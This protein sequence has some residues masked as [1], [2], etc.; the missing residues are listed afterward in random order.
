ML[1]LGLP[2]FEGEDG[3]VGDAGSSGSGTGAEG[4]TENTG[5]LLTGDSGST[6]QQ[7]ATPDWASGL[8]DELKSAPSLST[9][10][11]LPSFVK[12]ALEAEKLIGKKGIIKPGEN[13]TPEELTKYYNDLGRPEKAEQYAF[14]KPDGWPDNIPFAETMIPKVQE[15]FH[16]HGLT[17]EQARGVWA[18]YHEQIKQDY[19][20]NLST[21]QQEVEAGINA[22]KQEWGGEEKYKA[23]LETAKMAVKE[24]GGEKLVEFLN[25]TG[26]GDSPELIRAFANAGKQLREDGFVGG[27]NGGGGALS[28]EQAKAQIEQLQADKNFTDVL[29]SND[30]TQRNQQQ[31]AAKRMERLYQIA[32][33]SFTS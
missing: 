23:N 19:S 15:I 17:A 29:Y 28:S 24:F 6:N 5:S 30:P 8:P 26:F 21:S 25:K 33:P 13:A 32:Y 2:L 27:G 11:D 4:S 22:L 1:R 14:A 10:K 7:I 9:Y 20:S 12:S 3:G 16:K 18:D 31:E